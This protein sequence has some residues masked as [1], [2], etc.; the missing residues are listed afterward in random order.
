MLLADEP[1]VSA[2]VLAA[3]VCK[4]YFYESLTT[5]FSTTIPPLYYAT[6]ALVLLV[7]T[8]F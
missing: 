1:T 8:D 2:M 5:I 4:N 7:N 3:V 6:L